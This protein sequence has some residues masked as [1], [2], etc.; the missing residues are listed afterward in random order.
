MSG[1]TKSIKNSS[2]STKSVSSRIKET[3]SIFSSKSVASLFSF[4][5][6]SGSTKSIKNSSA[7]TVLISSEV[8]EE[9]STFTSLAISS[10]LLPERFTTIIFSEGS[11]F[12]SSVTE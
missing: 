2:A 1:S 12:G 10:S 8:K 7:S 5:A 6:M 9:S 11:K 4:N 3:F